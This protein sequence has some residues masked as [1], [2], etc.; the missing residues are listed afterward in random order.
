[1]IVMTSEHKF[2][3]LITAITV[4]PVTIV[5]AWALIS[6]LRQNK[7]RLEVLISPVFWNSATGEPILGQEWP[8]IVVRNQ[9]PFPL[10]ISNVGFRVGKKFYTFGKPLLNKDSDLKPATWPCE[11]ASRGRAAFYLNDNT[12]DGRTFI[13]AI[14]PILKDK[15]IWEVSRGYAMTECNKTFVSLKMSRKTLELLRKAAK[16]R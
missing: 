8:G 11:V 4:V 14:Q 9:S 7:P 2:Q 13:N 3:L 10:R 16:K 6:Q 15:L 12:S 5:S 1:V